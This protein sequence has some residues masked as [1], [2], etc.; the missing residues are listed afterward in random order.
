MQIPCVRVVGNTFL[1]FHINILKGTQQNCEMRNPQ[2]VQGQALTSL[3][4]SQ[5]ATLHPSNLEVQT[6]SGSLILLQEKW[7][8]L[9]LSCAFWHTKN[10]SKSSCSYNHKN[11][12]ASRISGGRKK[13]KIKEMVQELPS[14]TKLC[15]IYCFH[16]NSCDLHQWDFGVYF[17]FVCK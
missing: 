3:L 13:K 12:A 10:H 5:R 1:K 8:G 16:S 7:K 14:L 11:N 17:F 2:M 9:I 15:C 6:W 4:C